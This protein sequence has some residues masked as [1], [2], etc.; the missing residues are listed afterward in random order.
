MHTSLAISIMRLLNRTDRNVIE[1]H[2]KGK[3]DIKD[4][5]SNI[6]KIAE[7]F[8]P[9]RLKNV[10]HGRIEP[11]GRLTVITDESAGEEAKA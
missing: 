10:L 3:P 1:D 5:V 2:W 8:M 9:K 4:L 6:A 7:Y 11:K